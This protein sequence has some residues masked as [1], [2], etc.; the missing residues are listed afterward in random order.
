[1]KLIE[2]K[3]I[4]ESGDYE[5]ANIEWT[6]DGQSFEGNF[7]ENG[8]MY[9]IRLKHID[10]NNPKFRQFQY[11][12]VYNI[13]FSIRLFINIISMNFLN[14]SSLPKFLHASDAN[15]QTAARST[16]QSLLKSVTF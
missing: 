14:S 8:D 9:Q 11:K 15:L 1:M 4:Y 2:L 5:N 6:Q 16:Y 7:I 13:Q 3:N 10:L 12:I